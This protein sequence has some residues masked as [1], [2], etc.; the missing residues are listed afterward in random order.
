MRL[1]LH[2]KLKKNPQKTP[3]HTPQIMQFL[4]NVF[5]SEVLI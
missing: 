1:G 4:M 5:R 3:Q 2:S